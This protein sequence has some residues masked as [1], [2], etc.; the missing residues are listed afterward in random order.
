VWRHVLARF[1]RLMEQ[2]LDNLKPVMAA[3]IPSSHTEL[4]ALAESGV[5]NDVREAFQGRRPDDAG[6]FQGVQGAPCMGPRDASWR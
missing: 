5:P 6:V 2:V 3:A 4:L 1:Q